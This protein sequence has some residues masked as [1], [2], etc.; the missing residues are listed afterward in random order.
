MKSVVASRKSLV[1][2]MPEKTDSIDCYL[3]EQN[4]KLKSWPELIGTLRYLETQ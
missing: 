1:A 2:A 3:A 4:L